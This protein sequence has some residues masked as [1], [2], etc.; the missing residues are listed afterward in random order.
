MPLGANLAELEHAELIEICETVQLLEVSYQMQS[1]L[2]PFQNCESSWN[3][4]HS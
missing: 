2:I 3:E 4:D 1:C